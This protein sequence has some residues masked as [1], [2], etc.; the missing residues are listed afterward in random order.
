MKPGRWNAA[1]ATVETAY[2]DLW[3]G[4]VFAAP[5]WEGVVAPRDLITGALGTPNT[6]PDIVATPPGFAIHFDDASTPEERVDM[7]DLPEWE[8]P[9]TAITVA[10]TIIY[11]G[12][13]DRDAFWVGKGNIASSP[14]LSY[15]LSNSRTTAV[16][17]GMFMVGTSTG[18]ERASVTGDLDLDRVYNLVGRWTTGSPVEF[19]VDGALEGSTNPLGGTIS[20]GTLDD[21]LYLGHSTVNDATVSGDV[22]VAYIWDRWLPDGAIRTL[23]RDPFGLVRRQRLI[24]VLR[25]ADQPLPRILVRAS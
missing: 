18:F 17:D 20:Y 6:G 4:L 3:R 2:R 14:F 5:I 9:S 23:D 16:R 7:G 21:N 11:R 8:R 1:A 13:G 22:I 24:P 12:D 25:P 19:F 15:G 10:A